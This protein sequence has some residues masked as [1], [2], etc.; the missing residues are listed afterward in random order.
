MATEGI[1]KKFPVIQGSR[2]VGLGYQPG[3]P[4]MNEGLKFI[5]PGLADFRQTI[6]VLPPN[7]RTA[8]IRSL[9]A[10]NG[11]PLRK[12]PAFSP[13]A[14]RGFLMLCVLCA[15]SPE[16]A[17]CTAQ[18][19]QDQNLEPTIGIV[20]T[21]A[22]ADVTAK[23]GTEEAEIETNNATTAEAQMTETAVAA[24]TE[25]AGTPPPP[26]LPT[27]TPPRPGMP[28]EG[29]DPTKEGVTDGSILSTPDV[30][31]MSTTSLL[32][33]VTNPEFVGAY[34]WTTDNNRYEWR[35][36]QFIPPDDPLYESSSVTPIPIVIRVDPAVGA[37]DYGGEKVD[38]H[39]VIAALS[40]PTNLTKE[41]WLAIAGTDVGSFEPPPDAPSA[42]RIAAA[43]QWLAAQ[44]VEQN[45]NG[46]GWDPQAGL[47]YTIFRGSL[48]NA[49]SENGGF[50]WNLL[51][52][53]AVEVRTNQLH[54]DPEHP[55]SLTTSL[56]YGLTEFMNKGLGLR[57]GFGPDP[58]NQ[59]SDYSAALAKILFGARLSDDG[60]VSVSSLFTVK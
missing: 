44:T 54:L 41:P 40:D 51:P 8:L 18:A 23:A 56:L 60:R 39:D 34:R 1:G 13:V 14:T 9:F 31:G 21:Q 32:D 28:S 53:G 25:E 50:D 22:N 45:K 59:F 26:P 49:P 3:P 55:A 11:I 48:G 36:S 38:D 46:G 35:I 2:A 29:P 7:A 16:L 10:P 57:G 15:L 24:P 43:L 17:A 19:A 42:Q 27:N 33:Y 6:Q 20:A 47:V 37:I 52:N 12:E 4:T 58:K 30:F 5:P